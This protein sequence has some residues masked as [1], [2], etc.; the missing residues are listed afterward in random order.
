MGCVNCLQGTV[1]SRKEDKLEEKKNKQPL[2]AGLIAATAYF[3]G[4]CS[5][6]ILML[7]PINGIS[8]W[9]GLL[10]GVLIYLGFFLLCGPAIVGFIEALLCGVIVYLVFRFVV[11]VNINKKKFNV[12]LILTS[13]ISVVMGLLFFRPTDRFVRKF[14]SGKE[15]IG[16]VDT[17]GDGKPDKW[18]HDDIYGRLIE[19]DYDT[20]FDGKTDVWEYYRR[21]RQL[22]K[23]VVDADLDGKPDKTELI[24]DEKK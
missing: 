23:R 14:I 15:R 4:F 12:M 19:L 24:K 6:V 9:W 22:Y 21:N 7:F 18:V 13:F 17:N 1:G 5:I 2:R 10:G 11:S 8:D 3:F 16:T 20:N